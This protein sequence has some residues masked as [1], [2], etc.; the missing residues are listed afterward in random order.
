MSSL[1]LCLSLSRGTIKPESHLSLE[2]V[3]SCPESLQV[4]DL[5]LNLQNYLSPRQVHL[6]CYAANATLVEYIKAHNFSGPV[7][8]VCQSVMRVISDGPA[9]SS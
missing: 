6:A 8:K 3:P 5:N 2:S 7:S 1:S 4:P 9:P